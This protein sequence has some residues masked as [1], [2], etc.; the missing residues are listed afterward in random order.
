MKDINYTED[1][2]LNIIKSLTHSP[3]EQVLTQWN[4]NKSNTVL[5]LS[6]N[7]YTSFVYTFPIKI[8]GIRY[9]TITLVDSHNE[10]SDNCNNILITKYLGYDVYNKSLHSFSYDSDMSCYL[11]MNMKLELPKH[12]DCNDF[13]LY[14]STFTDGVGNNIKYR[15]M[16]GYPGDVHNIWKIY[17]QNIKDYTTYWFYNN[18]NIQI[19]NTPI[20]GWQ[21]GDMINKNIESRKKM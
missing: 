8:D 2:V 16:Y 10:L 15:I 21:L 12:P 4:N 17:S 1:D 14:E 7:P 18:I 3:P 9:G 11:T 6:K 19:Q 13:Y 5:D 20:A